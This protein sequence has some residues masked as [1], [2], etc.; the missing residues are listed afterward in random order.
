[1]RGGVANLKNVF[2]TPREELFD[3]RGVASMRGGVAI[4]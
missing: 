1:M 2:P 4:K 3:G